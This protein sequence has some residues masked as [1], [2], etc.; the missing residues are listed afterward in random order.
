MCRAPIFGPI[1]FKFQENQPM[2]DKLLNTEEEYNL[3]NPWGVS[4]ANG[5][6]KTTLPCLGGGGEAE[7]V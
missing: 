4:E 6:P 7:N 1:M 3:S 5:I 2:K